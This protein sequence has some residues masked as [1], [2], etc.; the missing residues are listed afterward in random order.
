MCVCYTHMCVCVCVCVSERVRE[1]EREMRKRPSIGASSTVVRRGND[2]QVEV[3]LAFPLSILMPLAPDAGWD[4][5]KLRA[6]GS[7][8]S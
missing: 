6:H 5:V 8:Q 2:A 1:R 4:Q 7:A 3:F